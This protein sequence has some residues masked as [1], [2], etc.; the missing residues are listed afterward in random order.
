MLTMRPNCE[1]CNCDLAPEGNEAT[2]CSFECTFC[3]HCAETILGNIC[4]NCSGALVTRPSRSSAL[5]E[6]FP[7][8]SERINKAAK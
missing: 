6:K 1:H 8:S 3:R 5:L 7:A 4:P 2:I